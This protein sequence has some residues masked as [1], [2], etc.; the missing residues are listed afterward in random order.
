[1]KSKVKLKGKLRVY[2]QLT[3][4]LGLMLACVDLWIYTVDVKA[5]IIWDRALLP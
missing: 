3:L 1:M 5:G 4:L 2:L